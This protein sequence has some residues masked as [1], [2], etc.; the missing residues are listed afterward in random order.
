[1]G[2][3]LLRA[4]KKQHLKQLVEGSQERQGRIP[5]MM[6]MKI[7]H[8]VMIDEEDEDAE[9][10]ENV[11]EDADLAMDEDDEIGDDGEDGGER[12]TVF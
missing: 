5:W 3:A 2:M 12:G 9:G 4:N 6:I 7:K 11:E 8:H 1:Y 10:D